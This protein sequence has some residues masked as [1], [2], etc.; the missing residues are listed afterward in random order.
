MQESK[1]I[2]IVVNPRKEQVKNQLK[3]LDNWISKH[4]D[5][6][7]YLLCAFGSK[8][9]DKHYKSF[10]QVSQSELRETADVLVT[11][12]G[13]GTILN[14]VNWL[15]TKVIPILGVNLGG[16]GFLAEI[17]PENLVSNLEAYLKGNFIVESRTLLQCTSENSDSPFYALNDLV[18]DKAGFHRVIEIITHVDGCLLNSYIADG[19]VLSS[20]TGSTGYS[21]SAGGP[22][23]VPQSKVII[24]NPI[25]P[26]SLTNRPVVIP[27]DCKITIQ[28]FTEHDCI[29]IFHDGKKEGSYPSG[30]LFTIEKADFSVQLVQVKTNAFYQTL[31]NK[32]GWGEDFR[33][34]NRWSYQIKNPKNAD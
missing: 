24:I 14:T 13:D 7:L 28:V 25:C 20:P 30:S 16:L 22:I 32:L 34:K 23:V 33:D 5:P 12:G 3:N 2:G 27:D 10:K 9:V 1:V 6:N 29:N 4:S 26:H 31:R 8:F 15:G 21:L 11:L 19:L 17:S 18:I